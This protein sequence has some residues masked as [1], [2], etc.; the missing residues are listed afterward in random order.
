[1]ISKGNRRGDQ[2]KSKWRWGGHAG[3]PEHG[4]EEEAANGLVGKYE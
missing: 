1:L 4:V 2:R 3:G